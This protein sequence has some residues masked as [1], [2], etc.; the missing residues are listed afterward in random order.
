VDIVAGPDA[1]RDLPTML[2]EIK[3]GRQIANVVLSLEETYDDIIPVPSVI[4]PSGVFVI[5]FRSLR[6]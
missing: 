1:Y 2:N 3:D 5:V 6:L 4:M